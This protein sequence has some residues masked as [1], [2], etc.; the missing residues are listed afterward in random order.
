MGGALPQPQ[1]SQPRVRSN[2]CNQVCDDPDQ[3]FGQ[4]KLQQRYDDASLMVLPPLFVAFI[5]IPA[6]IDSDCWLFSMLI[7][8][9]QV[10]AMPIGL[11]P[12]SPMH[13]I[14]FFWSL[15]ARLAPTFRSQSIDAWRAQVIQANSSYQNPCCASR[16][17]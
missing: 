13:H 2:P 7:A 14:A 3:R 4:D 6:R 17:L 8:V 10:G 9:S 1:F 15:P 11:A 12:G 16:M 5:C